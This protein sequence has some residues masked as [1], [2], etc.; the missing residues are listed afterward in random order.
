LAEIELENVG[1]ARISAKVD[2]VRQQMISDRFHRFLRYVFH[3]YASAELKM[4][5]E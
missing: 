4:V 3:A 2:P 5:L 1:D